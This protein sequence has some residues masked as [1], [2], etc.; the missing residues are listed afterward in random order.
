MWLRCAALYAAYVAIVLSAGLA[1]GFLHIEVMSGNA[2]AFLIVPLLIFI[3]PAVVEELFFR[4]ILL[5]HPRENAT[6]QRVWITATLSLAVFIAMHPLNGYLLRHEAFAV[7]SNPL[8]LFFAGLLGL[9]CTLAY[10]M[11]GSLWPPILM[12]WTTV[13]VW[14][15]F[16]GGKRLLTGA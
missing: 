12:H 1:T 13:V 10:R 3:R 11:S 14:T 8:F 16:L 2:R 5:P 15:V 4:A 6:P 9:V 7:F